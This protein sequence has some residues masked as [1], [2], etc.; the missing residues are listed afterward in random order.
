[1]TCSVLLLSAHIPRDL[2]FFP[3]VWTRGPCARS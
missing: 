3:F 1:L 2:H